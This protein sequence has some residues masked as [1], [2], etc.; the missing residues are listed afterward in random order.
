MPG[1]EIYT[2]S[3]KVVLIVCFYNIY[4]LHACFILYNLSIF[5]LHNIVFNVLSDNKNCCYNFF[6][7]EMYAYHMA[8][9][10][11][12]TSPDYLGEF[13]VNLNTKCGVSLYNS[14]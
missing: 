10:E 6:F 13:E 5:V 7:I 8:R 14:N 3:V 9:L 12:Y 1:V 11:I 4:F 2:F